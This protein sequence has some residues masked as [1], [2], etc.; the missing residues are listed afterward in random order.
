MKKRGLL[1]ALTLAALSPWRTLYAETYLTTDQA[2]GILFPKEKLTDCSVTL[3]AE[4]RESIAKASGVRVRTD[5]VKAWKSSDGGWLIVDNV[6]GKHEYIDLAVGIGKDGSVRGIEILTYRETYGGEVRQAKWRAQFTGKTAAA[7]L[8][9]DT[10]I[11]NIS[12]ATLSSVHV[13]EGVRRILHTW[14]LALK[15]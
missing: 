3:T 5:A 12:G 2:A 10:D 8:K 9:V 15:P 14:K 13:A 4:Q 1:K 6:L 7:S 11:K